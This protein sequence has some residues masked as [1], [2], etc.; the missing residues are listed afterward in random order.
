MPD[1]SQTWKRPLNIC[2]TWEP[3]QN[4]DALRRSLYLHSEYVP[5]VG[6]IQQTFYEHFYWTQQ[7][8]NTLRKKLTIY[9][10][11]EC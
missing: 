1:Y 6:K 9:S 2:I 3:Y 7:P 4:M 5:Y 11:F 10:V 8:Q